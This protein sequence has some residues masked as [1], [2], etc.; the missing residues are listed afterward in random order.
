MRKILAIDVGGTKLIYAV[1]NE[2]GGFLKKV[3][4][5]ATPKN[6]NELKALF[7]K[8]PLASILK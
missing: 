2:K 1:I 8:I 7:E 5:T 4:K 6:M 3:K